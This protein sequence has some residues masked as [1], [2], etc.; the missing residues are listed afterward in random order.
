MERA[1]E[2]LHGC[3][4]GVFFGKRIKIFGYSNDYFCAVLQM[5]R[6]KKDSTR[7]LWLKMVEAGDI[8][9]DSYEG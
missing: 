3:D 8:Y 7:D 9:K 2:R 4:F 1:Q 5:I 6:I